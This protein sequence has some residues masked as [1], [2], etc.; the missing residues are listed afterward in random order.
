MLNNMHI[1][2]LL[3]K[4]KWLGGEG[5]EFHPWGPRINFTNDMGCDQ[6]W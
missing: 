5:V 4:V 2:I 6:Q 1:T 3:Y